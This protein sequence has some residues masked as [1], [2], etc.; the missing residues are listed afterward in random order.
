MILKSLTLRN[1]RKFEHSTIEFPDGVT[2]V[3]GFNGVG[4]STIFEAVAWVLYGSVA[5]RTSADQIKRQG[6]MHSDPCRVELDFVFDGDNYR[7]IRDMSGKNLTASATVTVNGKIAATGAETVSRF[8]QKK[9]GMDFKSFF[10]SIF[11]KQKEL[12]TLSS[13]NASERRPLI[14]RML[15]IDSLDEI[16][17]EIRSDKKN[18]DLLIEKLSEKFVDENGK[19]KDE[20][21]KEK[22]RNFEKKKEE[23]NVL[24]KQ[25]KEKIFVFNKKLK[26]LEKDYIDSKKECEKIKDHKEKLA[27]KKILF[28]NKKKLQEEIK[29]LQ[30]KIGE[31][32]KTVEKEKKKLGSFKNLEES[33][34]STEKRLNEVAVLIENIIKKIEQKK[35]FA[36]RIRKDI[37]D[38][39]SKRKNIEKMGPDAKCPACE[40][41]L[42][43]Q[44]TVLLK[45]FDLEKRDKDK[46]IESFI[47]EIKKEQEEKDKFSREQQALQKKKS[48]LQNQSR[49]KERAG[50]TIRLVLSEIKREKSEVENKEKQVKELGVVIFNSKEFESVKK[51][52]ELVYKKYQDSLEILDEKKGRLT[53]LKLDLEK[54]EGEKKLVSQEIKNLID[55]IT[56]FDQFKKQINEEKNTVRYLGMLSDIMSSFRTHLISR[57]RP[58]L[59]SY[60][61]DFFE[62]LTD[63]KYVGMELDKN[64]DILIYDAG[65]SYGIERFSGGEEDL[66]NLC[67]RLAI[68]EVITERAGGIFN[69]IILDEIFGSQDMIRRQNI[70]KALNSLSSKFR[71]IFLITHIEDVK[72]FMENVINVTE[73]EEGTSRIVIE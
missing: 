25:S 2:G 7:I 68:S 35:T 18:K 36:E 70:M 23:I 20:I 63:G 51:Q 73:D 57:I 54:K 32:E 59:S 24:I 37:S 27:E 16:I 58:T 43:D 14:L 44:Y 9:L 64:Y 4:K 71:Q 12:N 49:E 41:V 31:R 6:A 48:F 22:I 33:I 65:N 45:K 28:E 8:V 13:M 67:L 53:V 34:S 55:K 29:D 66:A 1:F 56:E 3:V 11:A 17:K 62:R 72:N 38:I 10:T 26:T 47:K 69:F 19:N 61:S 50:V 5:A 46:E 40:R 52:V 39:D 15:G 60:S 42:S 30:K 21:Y